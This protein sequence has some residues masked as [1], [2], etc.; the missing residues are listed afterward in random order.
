MM[1]TPRVGFGGQVGFHAETSGANEFITIKTCN[2]T[3][4]AIDPDGPDGT[5]YNWIV[6]DS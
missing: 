5:T 2:P 3:G 1:V 6:F 4:A